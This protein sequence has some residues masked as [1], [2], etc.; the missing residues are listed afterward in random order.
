MCRFAVYLGADVRISK[1][2][3]EPKNSL[4][5]QSFQSQLREEPLNGDGFG[6]AWYPAFREEAPAL[7][8]STTP[9]WSNHNLREVARVTQTHCLLAHVRAASPGAAV[10]DL[11]CHPFANGRITFMHNGDLGGFTTL[12]RQLLAGL[13]DAAFSSIKGSTDSEHIFAILLDHL[14]AQKQPADP[15]EALAQA[16][17]ATIASVEELQKTHAP[18]HTSFLNLV[19]CDGESV[20]VTRYASA[21]G[22]EDSLYFSVG[23]TYICEKGVCRM[24]D[25]AGA[26]HTAVIVA[27]EPLDDGK[28][29]TRVPERHVVLVTPTLD[30]SVRKIQ[31]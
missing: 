24:E 1:L 3:T 17:E 9:A 27:S 8:K 20:A 15:T 4:I 13:S 21:R 5:H 18:H 26:K 19:L 6:I 28:Q 14:W 22:K 2:I 25:V 11:N 23:R 10:T 30:V 12:R 16:L 31:I 29:W 7:F